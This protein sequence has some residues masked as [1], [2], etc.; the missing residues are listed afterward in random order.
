[1][2]VLAGIGARCDEARNKGQACLVELFQPSD[3]VAELLD[4]LGVLGLFKIIT[5]APRFECFHP[6]K[7][8]QASKVELNRT[9]YEAH[10][11]LMNTSA[12][13]ERR[14]K[15]ATEFFEKNL[16]DSERKE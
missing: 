10:Q 4:N 3:R 9:C 11:T 7:E 12:D 2:G 13:N 5:E 16:R 8:A 1:L 6:V 14:F 15:D